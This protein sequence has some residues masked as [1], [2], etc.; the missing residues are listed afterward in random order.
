MH[1]SM[2]KAL[3]HTSKP[4]DPENV[5]WPHDGFEFIDERERPYPAAYRVTRIAFIAARGTRL[6]RRPR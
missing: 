3:P 6:A 5:S 2:S 4:K 1:V